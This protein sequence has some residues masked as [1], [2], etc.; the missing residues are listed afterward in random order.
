MSLMR[1]IVI[2]HGD[3]TKLCLTKWAVAQKSLGTC[4]L[5]GRICRENV[6]KTEYSRDTIFTQKDIKPP[7]TGDATHRDHSSAIVNVK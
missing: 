6:S 4:D 3:I 2:M 1:K 7:R 5:E